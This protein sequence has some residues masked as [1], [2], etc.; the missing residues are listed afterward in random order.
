[1]G[2]ANGGKYRRRKIG[3]RMGEKHRQRSIGGAYGWKVSTEKNRCTNEGKA[4]A[5]K[6]R[7]RV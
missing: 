5:E 7:R 6:Y 4:S 1:M 3:A 2:G